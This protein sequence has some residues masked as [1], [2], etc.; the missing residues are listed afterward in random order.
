MKFGLSKADKAVEPRHWLI[1]TNANEDTGQDDYFEELEW[2]IEHSPECPRET[3]FY[4]ANET[5]GHKEETVEHHTCRV[6][7][8]ILHNGIDGLEFV[9]GTGEGWRELEPGRY[10]IEAWAEYSPP[11]P[12]GGGEWDGGLRFVDP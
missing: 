5:L 12:N 9:T 2:E 1:I 7:Q 6:G 8:E 10:E 4:R 3:I 11:T